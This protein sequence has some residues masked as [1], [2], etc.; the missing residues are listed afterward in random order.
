MIPSDQIQEA[1]WTLL[2]VVRLVKVVPL[3]P[4]H[5]VGFVARVK[6]A[7]VSRFSL[8]NGSHSYN[9]ERKTSVTVD[10][11]VILGR[12][13]NPIACSGLNTATN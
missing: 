5:A 8:R 6:S 9:A 1:Y 2:R 11:A 13:R 7:M 3:N 4:D 12:S 10:T